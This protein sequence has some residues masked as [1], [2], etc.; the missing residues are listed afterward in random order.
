MPPPRATGRQGVFV[1]HQIMSAGG[2][3]TRAL[4]SLCHGCNGGR[5]FRSGPKRSDRYHTDAIASPIAVAGADDHAQRFGLPDR[6]HV[7]S[8]AELQESRCGGVDLPDAPISNE[9]MVRSRSREMRPAP[10]W[11]VMSS[12]GTDDPVRMNWPRALRASTA[13]RT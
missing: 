7:D 11:R 8:L 2:L 3:S 4:P 10:V 9:L 12:A 6:F 13:R 1:A 5:G